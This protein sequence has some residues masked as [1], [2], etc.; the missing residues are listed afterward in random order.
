M[1][2]SI[3]VPSV[4]TRRDTFLPV[5]INSLY[6]QLDLLPEEL[7]KEVEILFLV[8]NKTINLGKKRNQMAGLANGK[9]ISYVDDDDRLAD[10]YIS[11]ILKATEEDNDCIVFYAEVSVN[12]LVK[13]C[14]YSINYENVNT[15]RHYER[16]PNHI[17][18]VKRETILKVKFPEMMYGED[19]DYSERLKPLLKTQTKINRILYYYDFNQETSE[20]YK[21]KDNQNG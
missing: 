13:P 6:G 19:K 18:A 21:Y 1:K 4:H 11:S 9:Y 10:D 14:Y 15:P 17:C 12:G 5:M 20:T 8:D 3:L 7:K 16:S 2:L